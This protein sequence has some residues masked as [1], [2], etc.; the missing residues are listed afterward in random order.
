MFHLRHGVDESI[1]IPF[2]YLLYLINFYLCGNIVKD[3]ILT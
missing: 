3:C 2:E 1:D